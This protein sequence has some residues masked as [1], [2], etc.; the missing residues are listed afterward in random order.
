MKSRTT[1]N[2]ENM[3]RDDEGDSAVW[4]DRKEDEEGNNKD[5]KGDEDWDCDDDDTP[6][7]E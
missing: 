6:H 3:S 4:V 2:M 5:D 1:P 7:K